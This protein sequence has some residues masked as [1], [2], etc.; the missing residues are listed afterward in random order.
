MGKVWLSGLCAALSGRLGN[1]VYFRRGADTFQRVYQP[2]VTHP[3]SYR[4]LQVRGFFSD[5]SKYWYDLSA[6]QQQLWESFATSH[7]KKLSGATAFRMLNLN[8]L[9]ACHADLG[10]IYFPPTLPGTPESIRGFCVYPM[11]P[12]ANCITW[13]K[14][15]LT[16]NYVSASFRLHE[17]FC[18]VSPLYGLCPTDGYRPSF[19]FIE[20]VRSDVAEIVHTHNWPGG[21]RL[22]YKIFSLDACGRKSPWSHVIR[23]YSPD[24]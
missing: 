7:P 13:T 2:V 19:R 15:L 21:T 8:L 6:I 20:T 16:I 3:D 24:A 22:Y 18:C 5:L 12:T 23:V 10:C 11:S 9:G 1:I 17:M 4:Q 14:P